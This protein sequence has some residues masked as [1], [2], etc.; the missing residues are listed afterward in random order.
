MYI[1][2]KTCWLNHLDAALEKYNSR[3]HGTTKMTPFEAS[4]TTAKL[5]SHK[6]IPS[7]NIHNYTPAKLAWHKLPKFQVGDFV[8]VPDK[9][10]FIQM[11]IQQI[12]MEIF[13]KFIKLTKRI[14]FGLI[15]ENNE[16]IERKYYDQEHLKVYSILK[17]TTKR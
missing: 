2:R 3:V 1:K 13:S 17:L 14:P 7:N 8:R 16:Q 11:V 10:T 5:A 12:G 15:D 4:N 6:L 9:R